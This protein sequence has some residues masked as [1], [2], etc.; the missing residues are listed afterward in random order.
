M[1][2]LFSKQL[3][4]GVDMKAQIAVKHLSVKAV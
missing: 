4:R 3:P 2:G 1:K